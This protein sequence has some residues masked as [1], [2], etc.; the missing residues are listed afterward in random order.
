MFENSK[1]GDLKS[2]TSINKLQGIYVEPVIARKSLGRMRGFSAF[3]RKQTKVNYRKYSLDG[4]FQLWQAGT[5]FTKFIIRFCNLCQ[6]LS[7][8]YC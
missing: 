1:L 3:I 5:G 2:N 4:S 7:Y 8:V 6:L